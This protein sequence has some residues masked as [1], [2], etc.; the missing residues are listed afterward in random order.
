M[1]NAQPLQSKA[2]AHIISCIW[3]NFNCFPQEYRANAMEEND[4]RMF[5]MKHWEGNRQKRMFR[6]KHPLNMGLFWDM[7]GE[8]DLA[9]CFLS[10]TVGIDSSRLHHS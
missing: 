9:V 8:C 2:I 3:A 6:V 1:I 4:K 7:Y 5:H 10:S